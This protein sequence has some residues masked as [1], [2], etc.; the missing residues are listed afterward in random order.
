MKFSVNRK[1]IIEVL[2]KV[3]GITNRKTNLDVTEA[4]LIKA[5]GS[6]I[7]LNVNDLETGFEG[8]YPALVETEGIIAVNARRFYEI[9]RN[10]PVDKINI[11][12]VEN[13]WIEISNEKVKY[14]IVGMNA[15]DFPN[16]QII[17]DIEFLD[18]N[19]LSLKSIIN[20]TLI[21]GDGGDKR[22][23]IQGALFEVKGNSIRCVST[24][25]SRLVTSF[26][27]TDIQSDVK[28]LIPKKA[29]NEVSKFLGNEGSVR[30][31]VKGNNF[32]VKKDNETIIVRLL[33]GDFPEYKY[34]IKKSD[35]T[36]EI[37]INKKPFLMMLRRMSIF[38]SE[39]YK[40]AVFNFSNNKLAIIT[41]NPNIGESKEDM[42]IDF[43]GN[44]EAVFNPKYFIEALN[45]I[46]DDM[47]CVNIVNEEY[48][49]LVEGKNNKSFLSVIMPMRK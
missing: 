20:K 36:V 19:S 45:V 40:G 46:D 2:A 27:S 29:L 44:I 37:N 16:N 14:N 7:T 39:D 31:G 11:N 30:F 5:A 42:Q 3:Q 9:V 21:V 22:Q 32:I 38:S 41:T 10:F 12:E 23:H 1:D 28:A 25:G 18:T 17:D 13:G 48:P 33:E 24:D 4:V 49:C 43:N 26:Y 6:H 47:I 34:I 35:N 15:A 8:T